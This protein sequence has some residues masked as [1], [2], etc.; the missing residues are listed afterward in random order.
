MSKL[1]IIKERNS[2]YETK[3]K[4]C[5]RDLTRSK[6]TIY[7]MKKYISIYDIKKKRGSKKKKKNN[8]T[9]NKNIKCRSCRCKP[10]KCDKDIHCYHLMTTDRY[11]RS[12]KY[13]KYNKKG[14]PRKVTKRKSRKSK[15]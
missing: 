4:E 2:N 5:E 15:K 3:L 9:K 14:N 13:K 12:K 7:N 8:K 10:C 6:Q 11:K 1:S